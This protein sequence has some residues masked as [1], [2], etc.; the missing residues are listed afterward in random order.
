M[1]R[2]EVNFTDVLHSADITAASR[3][4]LEVRKFASWMS[5]KIRGKFNASVKLVLREKKDSYDHIKRNQV[6]YNHLTTKLFKF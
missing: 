2:M 1:G 6:D 5:W 4:L 3:R